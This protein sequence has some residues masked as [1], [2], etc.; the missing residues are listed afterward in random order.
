VAVQ[1]IAG[2]GLVIE[3]TASEYVSDAFER[4]AQP[5]PR[6][7]P[8]KTD[9]SAPANKIQNDAGDD[10]GRNARRDGHHACE[11][12]LIEPPFLYALGPLLQ[13]LGGLDGASVL[14]QQV[15]RGLGPYL[16]GASVRDRPVELA[17]VPPRPT[18]HTPQW[19]KTV[20]RHPP[21]P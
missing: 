21:E 3:M 14:L 11:R 18:W 15:Q 5:L 9:G 17:L 19:R 4:T 13:V 10:S 20:P 1:Q 6:C 16:S 7:A 2:K 8:Q 12:G